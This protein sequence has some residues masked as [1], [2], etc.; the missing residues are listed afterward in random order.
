[1]AARR[2]RLTLWAAVEGAHRRGQAF[3][4]LSVSPPEQE[5]ERQDAAEH[6]PRREWDARVRGDMRL[7]LRMS[8]DVACRLD[9]PA[10]VVLTE[11]LRTPCLRRELVERLPAPGVRNVLRVGSSAAEKDPLA[12][13]PDV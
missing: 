7:R 12:R 3:F 1:A 6:E 4:D 13:L 2:V 9:D 5:C 11:R 8:D 10:D